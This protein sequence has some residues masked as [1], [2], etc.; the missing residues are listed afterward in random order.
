MNQRRVTV[1]KKLTFGVNNLQIIYSLA[2]KLLI[3]KK[4]F[5]STSIQLI[6]LYL[7]IYF[8]TSFPRIHSFHL[9]YYRLSF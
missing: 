9:V 3:L 2:G 4:T 6:F 7:L 5:Y 1:N 8:M